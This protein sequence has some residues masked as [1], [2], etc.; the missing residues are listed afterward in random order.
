MHWPLQ[1]D[2]ALRLR[3][4]KSVQPVRDAVTIR[5]C[6]DF[7]GCMEEATE[8]HH[9]AFVCVFGQTIA[10]QF[11]TRPLCVKHHTYLHAKFREHVRLGKE[12]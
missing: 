6:C 10:D 2:F 4:F 9:I 12:L 3:P 11:R 8:K 1:K 7:E 5:Q